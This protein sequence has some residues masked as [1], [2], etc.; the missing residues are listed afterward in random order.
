[1]AENFGDLDT[2][3]LEEGD[4]DQDILNEKLAFDKIFFNCFNT[5]EGKRMFETL[6]ERHV[7]TA[8][9]CKGDTLEAVAY[10]QGMCDLILNMEACVND[11]LLPTVAKD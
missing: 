4:V 9:Y 3:I 1:M 10:R 5:P 2:T 7:E 11:V 6:R 8:I